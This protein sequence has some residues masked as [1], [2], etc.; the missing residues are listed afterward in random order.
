V[1][2][3]LA[4]LSAL[5]VACVV[6]CG[7]AGSQ[8]AKLEGKEAPYWPALQAMKDQGG[9]MTVGMS[10]QMQGPKAAKQAAA[11]PAFKQ[12]LDGFEKE[13]IPSKFSTPAREAA[14]KDFVDSLRKLAEAGSDEEI[15]TLWDKT[16]A[17][18]QAMSAP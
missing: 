2:R 3:L 6:G 17:S 9:L 7:G 16:Q 8:R 11:A 15:K 13:G 10:M 12:L 14:K 18:M 4:G 1:G 5:V